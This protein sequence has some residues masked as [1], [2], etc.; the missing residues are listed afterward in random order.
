MKESTTGSA[1]DVHVLGPSRMGWGLVQNR[2]ELGAVHF[3]MLMRDQAHVLVKSQFEER[4]EER[5]L[6]GSVQGRTG[7]LYHVKVA[8]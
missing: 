5:K 2:C 3:E 1:R 8:L 6:G 4:R 7:D